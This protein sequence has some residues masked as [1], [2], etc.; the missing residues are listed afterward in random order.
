[1][2]TFGER[3]FACLALWGGDFVEVSLRVLGGL[4]VRMFR[5]DSRAWAVL[6]VSLSCYVFVS[7]QLRFAVSVLGSEF[8]CGSGAPWDLEPAGLFGFEVLAGISE[9]N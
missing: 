1:M 4:L 5:T 7:L 3:L 6:V 8:F 2:F 9:V